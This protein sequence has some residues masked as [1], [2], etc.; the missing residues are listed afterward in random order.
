MYEVP[1]TL[2]LNGSV[3]TGMHTL[4][5]HSWRSTVRSLAGRDLR[6]GEEVRFYVRVGDERYVKVL[7]GPIEFDIS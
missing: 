4:D 6:H 5:D 1:Y 3:R 2:R 7:R